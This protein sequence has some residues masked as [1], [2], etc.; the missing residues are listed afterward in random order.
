MTDDIII[1][2][3]DDTIEFHCYQLF[4]SEFGSD[5]QKT[6]VDYMTQH[7]AYWFDCY[8]LPQCTLC[9]GNW[10]AMFMSGIKYWM[11]EVY[12]AMPEK[13]YTANELANI[14]LQWYLIAMLPELFVRICL[15]ELN[16]DIDDLTLYTDVY[17][18]LFSDEHY[19]PMHLCM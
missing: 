8:F 6:A 16:W 10:A 2:D 15:E 5:I 3:I 17:D 9:G 13:S 18:W 19:Q 11:P 14:V 4:G 7:V 12:D 1:A